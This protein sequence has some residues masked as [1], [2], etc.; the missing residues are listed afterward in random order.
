MSA[1]ESRSEPYR[2][3]GGVNRTVASKLGMR[4]GTSH[5]NIRLYIQP[6]REDH[7]SEYI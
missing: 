7:D 1:D 5:T 4:L 2:G 6:E 3:L